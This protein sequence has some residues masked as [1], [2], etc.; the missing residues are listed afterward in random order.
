MHT[1]IGQT[2]FPIFELRIPDKVSNYGHVFRTGEKIHSL[3]KFNLMF[4]TVEKKMLI[5]MILLLK[6]NEVLKT[7]KSSGI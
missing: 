1:V 2:P 3:S 4:N 7:Y 6:R 5:I